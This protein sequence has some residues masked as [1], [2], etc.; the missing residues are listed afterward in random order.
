MKKILSIKI[1]ENIYLASWIF[2]LILG[3]IF[4]YNLEKIFPDK[5]F[6]D[7]KTILNMIK[8]KDFYDGS[9][10][11][12][13]LTAYIFSFIPIK[14]LRDYNIFLYL[15]FIGFFFNFLLKVPRTIK[16]YI[17]N[18]MYLFLSIIYLLRPGK[19]FLQ[20]VMLGF[21]YFYRKYIPLFLIV[22]GII[23]RQYL[24]L[25]AGIYIGIWILVNKKNKKIWFIVLLILFVLLNIKFPE[26][27]FKI[28]SVR[29]G[30]N[31]YRIDSVD[32]KT[33]ILN[34][35]QGKSIMFYYINYLINFFRLLFPIELIL[36]NIKYIPYIV[37][38]IWLSLKLWNWRKKLKHE[39]VILL[40]SYILVS[41]LFEPDFGSFLRHT[42]PYFIFILYLEEKSEKNIIYN[43]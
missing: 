12:N 26:L 25:Q 17:L 7:S 22:G 16:F 35:F 6:Y 41:I 28:F 23:F 43:K 15:I 3:L 5:Y 10:D 40:Y 31:K 37:F 29:D 32:A 8:M 18:F 30:V 34:I 1:E 21:C 38:Q 24:I 27:I 42:V 33:I 2:L 13:G 4:T 20:L 14:K 19:E 36:K 11:S 9:G 39:Y